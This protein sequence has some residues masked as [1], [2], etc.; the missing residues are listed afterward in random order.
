[1]LQ[2]DGMVDKSQLMETILAL[3]ADTPGSDIRHQ[4][5]VF[6]D[7]AQTVSTWPKAWSE[8]LMTKAAELRRFIYERVPVLKGV[9][10]QGTRTV[11]SKLRS[12]LP[13]LCFAQDEDGGDDG[14]DA[15]EGIKDEEKDKDAENAEEPGA[16]VP[17]SLVSV[18]AIHKCCENSEGSSASL[19]DD[20]MDAFLLAVDEL[21]VSFLCMVQNKLQFMVWSMYSQ[22]LREN[23][24]AK[25]VLIDLAKKAGEAVVISKEAV[26][27]ENF[28]MM[29]AGTVS[30]YP[31]GTP[32]KDHYPLCCL[33]GIPFFVNAPKDMFALDCVVPAWCTKVV[34]RN[35][36]AYFTVQR[37]DIP[38]VMYMSGGEGGLQ[39]QFANAMA[40]PFRKVLGTE[41]C[42]AD[43]T[44]KEQ[45]KVTEKFESGHA[46]GDDQRTPWYQKRTDGRLRG[47][48]FML[49][50]LRLRF[51]TQL[52]VCP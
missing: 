31:H 50:T 32:G 38:V 27:V 44:Q 15:Q 18:Q 2:C 34:A 17:S 20:S 43:R 41:T 51:N 33:F 40:E 22:H 47:L 48:E 52:Y 25:S 39:M 30:M 26:L 37:Q 10:F 42:F 24:L 21:D 46:D 5:L 7:L 8:L 13:A 49:R 45:R 1:M 14:A 28:E 29:M 11:G 35:D 12:Y 36:M 23:A 19:L 4:E 9:E 16:L 6:F 3:K